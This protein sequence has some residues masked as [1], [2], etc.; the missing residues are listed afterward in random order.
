MRSFLFIAFLLTAYPNAFAAP[1]EIDQAIA[2]GMP[3]YSIS[4]MNGA[5]RSID[6]PSDASAA[7]IAEQV[8]RY[9]GKGDQFKNYRIIE[10]KNVTFPDAPGI[11]TAI[12]ISSDRGSKTLILAQYQ[13]G[14]G[15]WH[16]TFCITTAI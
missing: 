2:I 3:K 13:K 7:Q 6:L 1:D 8:V 15:W 10:T 12:L 9:D 11:Y 14:P 5:Y 4:W 16:R